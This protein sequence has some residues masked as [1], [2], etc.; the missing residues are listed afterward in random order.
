MDMIPGMEEVI[1][2]IEKL[3]L[4]NKT[5]KESIINLCK[6]NNEIR[7][8]LE[9]IKKDYNAYRDGVK[10]MYKSKKKYVVSSSSEEEDF[11]PYHIK[12]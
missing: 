8:E 1:K 2:H 6:T 3:E 10:A 7:E 12:K 5:L 11:N 4:E 9:D